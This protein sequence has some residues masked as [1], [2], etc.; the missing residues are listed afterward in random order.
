M[1]IFVSNQLCVLTLILSIR[2]LRFTFPSNPIP[3][4]T[5]PTGIELI[6]VE[7][8]YIYVFLPKQKSE[9]LYFIIPDSSV[10]FNA[11]WSIKIKV[12]LYVKYHSIVFFQNV[13]SIRVKYVIMN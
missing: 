10:S 2:H 1:T 7:M 6:A 11:S 4:D 9:I 13:D 5:H 8:L 12:K 3:V